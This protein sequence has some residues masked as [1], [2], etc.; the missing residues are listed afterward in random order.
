MAGPVIDDAVTTTP[1]VSIILAIL[2][3]GEIIEIRTV[4]GGIVLISAGFYLQ[5]HKKKRK[6][7][8]K[9]KHK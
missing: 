5:L 4:I 1:I 2:W 3:I 8:E 6:K 9:N 7:I